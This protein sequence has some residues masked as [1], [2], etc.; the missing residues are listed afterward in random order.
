MATKSASSG[1]GAITP[2]S[3]GH[4]SFYDHPVRQRWDNLDDGETLFLEDLFFRCELRRVGDQLHASAIGQS[5]IAIQDFPKHGRI[6][7]V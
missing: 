5:W 4:R 1:Y 7:C 3:T 6:T 2:N